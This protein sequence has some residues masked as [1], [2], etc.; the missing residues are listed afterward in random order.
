MH[1]YSLLPA[2]D[3]KIQEKFGLEKS[4]S[5]L[6]FEQRTALMLINT[7]LAVDFPEPLQPNMIQIGGLQIAENKPLKE[8]RKSFVFAI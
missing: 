6:E 8:V 4:V 3:K 5:G 2:L 1:K 7:D